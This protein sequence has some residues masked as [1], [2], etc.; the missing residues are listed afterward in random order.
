MYPHAN[1][2]LATGLPPAVFVGVSSAAGTTL[3]LPGGAAAGDLALV[4]VLNGTVTDA[5]WTDLG[6]PAWNHSTVEVYDKVLS[7]GDISAGLVNISGGYGATLALYRGGSSAALR[8]SVVINGTVGNSSGQIVVPGFAHSSVAR[9]LVIFGWDRAA[10]TTVDP[11]Q[12]FTKRL[13]YNGATFAFG[14]AIA[15]ADPLPYGGGNITWTGFSS[16]GAP[17]GSEGVAVE[18]L[19]Q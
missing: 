9:K 15:D 3:A 12:G 17:N 19:G 11:N 18:I 16:S 4:G 5:G 10:L 6:A 2:A 14:H 13:G 8:T 7:A 1:L